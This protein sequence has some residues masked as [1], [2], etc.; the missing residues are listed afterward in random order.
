MVLSRNGGG[1]GRCHLVVNSRRGWARFLRS[2]TC[3]VLLASAL[4]S[5]RQAPPPRSNHVEPGSPLQSALVKLA[6]ASKTPIGFEA[7]GVGTPR[8]A[9]TRGVD[10][11]GMPPEKA[12][13]L[14]LGNKSPYRW[15]TQNRAVTIR[16]VDPTSGT[17]RASFLDTRVDLDLQNV[18]LRE[19]AD[20][21][22]QSFLRFTPPMQ[23]TELGVPPMWS[24]RFSSEGKGTIA[25]VL[26]S[27]V[28]AHGEA[29]WAVRYEQVD[30][31]DAP[32]VTI[33]F[34]TFDFATF[35]MEM[36]RPGSVISK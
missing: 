25:G 17:P 33:S 35:G 7:E 27:A 12:L 20:K 19:L 14:L 2:L 28:V 18:T 5:A 24:R 6:A 34:T 36:A 3:V 11:S 29:T 32:S 15:F 8:V 16:P 9:L 31:N 1:G 21:L 10:L 23:H 22:R 13:P 26:T 30:R 4:V